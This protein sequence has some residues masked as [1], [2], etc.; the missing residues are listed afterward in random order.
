MKSRVTLSVLAALTAAGVLLPGALSAQA[1]PFQFHAI[2]PCRVFDTRAVGAQT[3]GNPLQNP[4]PHCFQVRG[5]CGVPPTAAA[6]TL[7]ATIT[8][9]TRG[10]DLRLYPASAIPGLNDPSTMNYNAGEAALANGAI[11]PLATGGGCTNP[12]DMKILIGM[13][14]SGTVHLI[15]DVTGYFE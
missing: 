10:G 9:P 5:I 15:V 6:A 12:D 11:L 1:G 2:T 3:N 8:Q 7:N 13:I 4:G 14:G